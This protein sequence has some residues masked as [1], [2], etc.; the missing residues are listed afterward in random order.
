[1]RP[2]LVYL[3]LVGCGVPESM[4]GPDARVPPA[5]A[6][7][8]T[9]AGAP[10]AA[11]QAATPSPQSRPNAVSAL[12]AEAGMLARCTDDTVVFRYWQGEYPGPVV[13]V[14]RTLAVE[15]RDDPCGGP[16]RACTAPPG[17]YHQWAEGA[18]TPP[19]GTDWATL[20][21]TAEYRLRKSISLDGVQVAAGESVMVLSYIAEGFCRLSAIGRVFEESCPGMDGNSD[22]VWEEVR[23][24]AVDPVQLLRVPCVGA[25]PGWLVVNDAWMATPGVSQGNMPDFGVVEKAPVAEGPGQ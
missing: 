9:V 7:P 11:P 5:T 19:S 12:E 4:P 25:A 2:W 23:S 8:S 3:G 22:E 20:A 17:L 18:N 6:A 24:M 15:V 16:L 13:Q 21:G 1:M 10:V 14:N